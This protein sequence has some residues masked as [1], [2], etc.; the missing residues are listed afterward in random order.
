MPRVAMTDRF[1]ATAK[2]IDGKRTD[3]F[4]A[5]SKGLSLRVGERGHKGWSYHF[6]S[7]KNG[8]RG[9]LAIGTYP[10]T[11][12]AAARARAIEARGHV[13]DGRDPRDVFA[14]N[15]ASAMTVKGLIDSYLEKHVRP[16]LRTAKAI[17][18]RFRKNV[19]PVIGGLRLA[20]LH[21]REINRVIDPILKRG[22]PVEA[23]R[24]FE[25]IRALFRWGVARGDLDSNPIEG[26]RKPASPQPRERVLSDDE[27]ATLWNGLPK[28]LARSKECQR[29]IKLCLVT[30]QRVGEIA[31][32]RREELD[33]NAQ[34]WKLPGARTKN[35]HKHTVPLSDLAVSIIE[36]ALADADEGAEF[37]FPNAEG[38]GPLP[39]SAVAKTITRAQKPDAEG[40]QGRF[41]MDHWTAHD[42]RRSA[43]TCMAQLGIAPIVL[44]HV[45]NHRSVTKAGVT[46]SVYT[47][48]DHAKEKKHA[49]DIWAE[50]LAAIVGDDQAAAVLPMRRAR[51]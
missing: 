15:D 47:H 36:E 10:G 11:S 26:M 5:T 9:R 25:D 51:P 45:I 40:P 33:L 50:R 7:P 14:A 8:K 37:V 28:A 46:L 16:N 38:D 21:R 44:G 32:M 3:Y 34:L 4:D 13:E 29:I 12:L 48:Y 6:T 49:L 19:T 18:R 27:I 30:A 17:E 39:P 42:L 1:V 35:K 22:R 41:G 2:P 43:I 20:D 24:S 31:G 23:A